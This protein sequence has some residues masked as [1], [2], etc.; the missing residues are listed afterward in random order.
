MAEFVNDRMLRALS[1]LMLAMATASAIQAQGLPDPTRPS[2]VPGMA[3]AA[4]VD[5]SGPVLQ[6][7][8][9]APGRRL[10]VVSGQTLRVGDKFG[11]ARVTRISEGSVDLSGNSGVQT[12]KLYPDVGKHPAAKPKAHKQ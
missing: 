3:G 8:L 2:A 7:V 12:L 5:A 4:P 1:G 9:I 6:S 11:E 10:A